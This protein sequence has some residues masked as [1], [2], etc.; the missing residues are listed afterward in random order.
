MP[1]VEASIDAA[2]SGMTLKMSVFIDFHHVR[3]EHKLV[4]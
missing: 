3:G 1:A 2:P 4:L